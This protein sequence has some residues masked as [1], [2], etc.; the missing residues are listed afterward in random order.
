MTRYL[1]N[2]CDDDWS[3]DVDGL[4]Q[5]CREDQEEKELR[6]QLENMTEEEYAVFKFGGWPAVE[7]LWAAQCNSAFHT[8]RKLAS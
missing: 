4:C 8:L 1:C 3:D 2:G 5:S 6:S 7:K